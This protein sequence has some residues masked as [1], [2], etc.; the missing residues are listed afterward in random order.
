MR[1]S[2]LIALSVVETGLCCCQQSGVVTYQI[3]ERQYRI[4]KSFLIRDNVPWLPASQDDYPLLVL[5]PAS[6]PED[7]ISVLVEPV[8]FVCRGLGKDNQGDAVHV[9][10][11]GW[12]REQPFSTKD[13]QTA[14]KVPDAY[15]VTR[16][17]YTLTAAKKPRLIAVCTAITDQPSNDLCHHVYRQQDLVFTVSFNESELQALP[18]IRYRIG[19]YLKEWEVRQ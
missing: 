1:S 11:V 10:Q 15:N 19:R 14:H 13:I 2:L 9:C 8:S 17:Y 3:G 4:P 7:R 5:N 18:E 12:D 16:R 6:R